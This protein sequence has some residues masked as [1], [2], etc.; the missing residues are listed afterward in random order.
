MRSASDFYTE[1]HAEEKHYSGANYHMKSLWPVPALNAWAA[2]V[3]S[4]PV[5]L[6][7][8]G[9]GKGYFIRDFVHGANS[10]WGVQPSRVTGVDIVRSSDDVFSQVSP[11]FEFI[12]F[13][14]DG[15]ALPFEAGTFDFISCNHVLEHVFETEKL[16]REF[17]RILSADGLCLIA[18]PNLA[19]SANSVG[20]LW[21]NQKLGSEL[22]TEC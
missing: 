20:F 9:C 21:G 17:R 6:L 11:D 8:V 22:G 14:T 16:V 13:D 2:R 5:R 12:Q 19:C 1:L 15:N 7:D 4:R 3:K 10:R 18:V